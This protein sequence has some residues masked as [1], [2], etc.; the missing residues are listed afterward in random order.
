MAAIDDYDK[1]MYYYKLYHPDSILREK[2]TNFWTLNTI[3][4]KFYINSELTL[5][6]TLH[7]TD[8]I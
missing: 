4:R 1:D 5:N 2:S 6:S 7:D 8:Q 3:F